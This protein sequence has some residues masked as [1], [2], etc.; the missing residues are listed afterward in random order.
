MIYSTHLEAEHS[1][2]FAEDD[3]VTF[4]DISSYSY[5]PPRNCGNVTIKLPRTSKIEP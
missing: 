1:V 3:E 4:E 2:T 5:L